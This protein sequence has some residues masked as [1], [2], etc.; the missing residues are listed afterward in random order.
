M[1]DE[2]NS[3]LTDDTGIY[4]LNSMSKTK[5]FEDLIKIVDAM[6]ADLSK[7]T[8]IDKEWVIHD[9]GYEFAPSIDQKTMDDVL[10]KSTTLTRSVIDEMIRGK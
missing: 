4:F 2:L 7:L 8:G 10:G 3:V 1:T 6:A 9:Y 5:A